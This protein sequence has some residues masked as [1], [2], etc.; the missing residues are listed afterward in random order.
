V[1]VDYLGN[2]MARLLIR[3]LCRLT[4]ALLAILFVYGVT[5]AMEGMTT[6]IPT[7]AL[8]EIVLTTLW[9]APIAVVFSSADDIA[10]TAKSNWVFWIIASAGLALAYYLEFYTTDRRVTH[11]AAPIVAFLISAIPHCFP[12]IKAAY[13]VFSFFAA[14]CGLFVVYWIGRTLM[15]GS[16]FATAGTAVCFIAF[17]LT[18]V[19]AAAL[20][21]R[22]PWQHS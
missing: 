7:S 11:I 9:L 3:G 17:A 19:S 2:L 14:I 5:F 15:S 8:R 1:S 21:F 4:A 22:V 6:R 18:S 13:S 12:R 16:R 10:T 20:S